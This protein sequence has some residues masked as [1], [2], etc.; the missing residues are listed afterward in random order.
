MKLKCEAKISII[1]PC[2]NCEQTI[3]RT[4]CSLL[5]QGIENRR[6]FEIILVDDG[7][8]DRTG[9]LCDYYANNNVEVV[10][11]HKENGGLV[12]A[13]KNGVKKSSTDYVAFCDS[14]DYIEQNYV[15][16]VLAKVDEFSPDVIVY[17]MQVDYLNGTYEYNSPNIEEG[18]YTDEGVEAIRKTMFSDDS[19][20]SEM[21]LAS[22]CNK[23]FK[24]SLLLKVMDEIPDDISFGEDDV[25]TFL[26]VL[27]CY[28]IYVMRD[29][30][31]YHYVRHPES[32]IGGYDEKVFEKI[33]KLNRTLMTIAKKYNYCNYEQIVKSMFST[34]LICM[35]KEIGRNPNGFFNVR[36]RL[37]NACNSEVFSNGIQIGA[38]K[39][40]A[41]A[42]RL[43][44]VCM[45]YKFFLFSYCTVKVFDRHIGRSV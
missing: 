9:E 25:T 43:F 23:V 20:Q 13:W 16:T 41:I 1:V 18:Y 35:K 44:A 28:S 4:V 33:D 26:T 12:D 36:R 7:S 34:N 11:I 29:F 14:D 8:T 38:Y 22:R 5:N 15:E 2:Y 17:G 37:I 27:N 42:S 21:L 30:Y 39:G 19:M 32:M 40:Y 6:C 45:K 24:K 3:E 10:A 31:P